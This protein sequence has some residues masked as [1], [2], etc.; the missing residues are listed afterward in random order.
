MLSNI[1]DSPFTLFHDCYYANFI[2]F[3]QE[4]LA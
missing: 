1:Y 2:A 3:F 4:T